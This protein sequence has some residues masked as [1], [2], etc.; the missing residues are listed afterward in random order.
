MIRARC[1]LF[2]LIALLCGCACL[3]AAG[4]G[5]SRAYTAAESAFQLES[6]DYADKN[7]AE[8]TGKYPKSPRVPEAIL[9]QAKA[10]YQLSQF[11]DVIAILST[12]RFR[13]GMWQDDYIYWIAQ[14]H[15]RLTNFQAA[16]DAF[17]ELSKN[18]PDSPHRLEAALAEGAAFAAMGDWRRVAAFLQ[19]PTD[20]FQQIAADEPTNE[21]VIEGYLLLGEAQLALKNFQGADAAI[22]WLAKS[23]LSPE[24]LWRKKYLNCRLLLAE[25]QLQAALENT[26]NLLAQA[27]A[28]A[29]LQSGTNLPVVPESHQFHPDVSSATMLSQSVS[30]HG[31]VLERQRRIPEAI[32]AYQ[33]NLASGVPLDQQRHALLKI[34]ELY[35]A[36]TNAVAAMKALES[37]LEQH[38]DSGAADMALLTL[39]ELQLKQAATASGA[40]MVASS[41]LIAQARVQFD[42]VLSGYP[43]S[44]LLGK[45][46]LDKGWC[47][48]M[49]GYAQT[50][51]QLLRESEELFRMAAA[52]L[53]DS[54]DQA[55]TRFK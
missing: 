20:V 42:R 40:A 30:F 36:Q 31:L 51:Q 14:A 35:L 4:S 19:D 52:R 39:G 5:E 32:A 34:A 11:E 49:Q 47:S 21:F 24:A 28:A 8:F 54:Q 53:P 15:S 1:N 37:Y 48:W 25:G 50:N 3:Q 6:W 10:K 23:S 43:L 22:D 9:F 26:T 33:G 29:S 18:F 45:A 7:F 13:A 2:L 12:N 44:P 27:L 17:G 46:L 41:N 55:I 16:A 38:A